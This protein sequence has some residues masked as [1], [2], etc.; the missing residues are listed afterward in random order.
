MSPTLLG[1]K[2]V[3]IGP[4]KLLLYWLQYRTTGSITNQCKSATDVA[5]DASD[6]DVI[7]MS[8][9][10]VKAYMLIITPIKGMV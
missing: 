1:A 3:E 9:G 4:C 7:I 5:M 2:T 6:Y 8:R 10:K